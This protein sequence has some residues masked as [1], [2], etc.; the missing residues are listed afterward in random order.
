ME[1]LISG[2]RKVSDSLNKSLTNVFK[3]TI[4][5]LNQPSRLLVYLSFVSESQ[6]KKLNSHNRNIDKVTDVLSFPS[7]GI[8]AGEII[9][10]NYY[11]QIGEID[12]ET[13]LVI[14]GDVILCTKRVK[15]QAKEYGHTEEDEIVRLFVHSLLHLF[16]Y[17]HIK[18]E[19]YNVMHPLELEIL[20]NCGYNFSE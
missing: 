17:D 1:I 16:G 6:I 4:K 5:R 3:E 19:D 14:L 2:R 8:G 10:Y 20:N 18:D 11:K 9:D 15:E 13:G 12:F 7:L